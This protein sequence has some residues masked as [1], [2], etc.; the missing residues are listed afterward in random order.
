[1]GG[2]DRPGGEVRRRRP[3][4]GGILLAGDKKNYGGRGG[5]GKP[6]DPPHSQSQG[7]ANGRAG[8]GGLGRRAVKVLADVRRAIY[9]PC[10][11]KQGPYNS[12]P[13]S[14]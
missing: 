11:A 12:E 10:Q 14:E 13:F 6:D 5:D 9:H 3:A 4:R 8:L 1:M 2:Q 7:N